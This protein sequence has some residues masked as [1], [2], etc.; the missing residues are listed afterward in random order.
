MVCT[1]GPGGVGLHGLISAHGFSP[2]RRKQLRGQMGN[3]PRPKH[4]S[5]ELWIRGDIQPTTGL[6]EE[7]A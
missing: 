1:L 3:F 2:E 4:S 7:M 5:A 6:Q